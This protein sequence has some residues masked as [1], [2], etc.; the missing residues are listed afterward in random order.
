[1]ALVVL[2]VCRDQGDQLEQDASWNRLSFGNAFCEFGGQGDDGLTV[3]CLVGELRLLHA[4]DEHLATLDA[5][6]QIDRAVHA[7]SGCSH[8]AEL[9]EHAALP[10]QGFGGILDQLGRGVLTVYLGPIGEGD[11]PGQI[12]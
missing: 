10:E 2:Q 1:M 8:V 7:R 12:R 9:L 5:A 11:R 6:G 4:K 3:T